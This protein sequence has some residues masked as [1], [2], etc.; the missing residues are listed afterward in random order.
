MFVI[1]T[2]QSSNNCGAGIITAKCNGKQRTVQIDHSKSNEANQA[3]AVGA[4]LSVLCSA[5]QMAKLMHPSGGQRIRTMSM[6][7]AGGRYRW[8]V[9]V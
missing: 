6:S 5:E 7:D 4:L 3:R 2:V 1:N 9:D 8:T